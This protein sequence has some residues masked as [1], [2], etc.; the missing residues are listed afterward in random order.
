MENDVVVVGIALIV[1]HLMTRT[2]IKEE[3]W[4]LSSKKIK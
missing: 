3:V 1:H 4:S 2:T